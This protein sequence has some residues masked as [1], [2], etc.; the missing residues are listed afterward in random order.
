M[1]WTFLELGQYGCIGF[2]PNPGR[3][4]KDCR[5][6][7][8]QFTGKTRQTFR[9]VNGRAHAHG[10]QLEHDT[11]RDMSRR[12]KDNRGILWADRQDDRTHVYIRHNGRVA[13]QPHLWLA[14]RAG[15]EIQDG[16]IF[17]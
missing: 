9:E 4:K 11:L 10:D 6:N 12:E 3:R 15:S 7:R 8:S 13:S 17:G 5:P 14:R 2:L 1:R 16:W